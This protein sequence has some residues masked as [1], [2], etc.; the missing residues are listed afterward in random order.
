MMDKFGV[1]AIV[2][3][4]S[5]YTRGRGCLWTAVSGKAEK[6]VQLVLENGANADQIDE[7]NDAT[8]LG[9]AICQREHSIIPILIKFG[10]SLKMAKAHNTC[11]VMGRNYNNIVGEKETQ[12]AIKEGQKLSG[13]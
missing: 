13:Q 9:N 5:V 8:P 7:M 11:R 1:K 10:A 2:N 12:D 6:M 4:E 3:A